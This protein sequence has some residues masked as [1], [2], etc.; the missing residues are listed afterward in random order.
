MAQSAGTVEYTDSISSE[1]WDFFNECPEYD[2]KQS[3]DEAPVILEL[4]ET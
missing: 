3:D 2:T 4:W 1:G